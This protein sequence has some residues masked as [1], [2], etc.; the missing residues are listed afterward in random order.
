MEINS[1]DDWYKKLNSPSVQV[2]QEPEPPILPKEE[3]AVIN[4]E[5]TTVEINDCYKIL[6]VL[7]EIEQMILMRKYEN[8]D[9]TDEIK[10]KLREVE[11]ML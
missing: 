2:V 11:G 8:I 4:M 9:N 5:K 7:K 10:K 3:P 6:Y 1:L